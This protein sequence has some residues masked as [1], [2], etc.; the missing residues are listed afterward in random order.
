[1]KE[2]IIEKK[3]KENQVCRKKGIFFIFLGASRGLDHG[4][5]KDQGFSSFGKGS[6]LDERREG[7]LEIEGEMVFAF[8]LKLIQ[9][10][11]RW[12]GSPPP[13]PCSPH[14]SRELE[15]FSII[16]KASSVLPHRKSIVPL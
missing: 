3:P 6:G 1:M 15:M 10:D 8:F 16:R 12:Q 4:I 9:D 7:S 13:G 11:R 14:S 2:L 5:L